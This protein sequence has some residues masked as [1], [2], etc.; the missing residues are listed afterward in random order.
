MLSRHK[1]IETSGELTYAIAAAFAQGG[2]YQSGASS[3]AGRGG[4]G[5]RAG[6]GSADPKRMVKD[7]YVKLCLHSTCLSHR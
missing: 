7:G 2:N 5:A 3:G 1:H 6:G 4:G